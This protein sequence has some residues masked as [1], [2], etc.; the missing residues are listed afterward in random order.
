MR[1]SVKKPSKS[2]NLTT[3]VIIHTPPEEHERG[4][5]NIKNERRSSVLMPILKTI[6][7]SIVRP[8]LPAHEW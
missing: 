5:N 8:I 2:N 3:F 6:M 1:D 7:D 4:G